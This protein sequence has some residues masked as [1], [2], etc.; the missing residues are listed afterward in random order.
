MFQPKAKVKLSRDLL[1]AGNST[2]KVIS[3]G[4][5][6]SVLMKGTHGVVE[7]VDGDGITVTLDWNG[8]FTITIERAYYG[9]AFEDQ[10]PKLHRFKFKQNVKIDNKIKILT[11]NVALAEIPIGTV[12]TGTAVEAGKLVARITLPGK[13]ASIDI[14]MSMTYFLSVTLPM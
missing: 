7:K 11:R 10:A 2:V 9:S 5:Q 4:A 12:A 8:D 13:T 6:P 1:V 14:E 3:D